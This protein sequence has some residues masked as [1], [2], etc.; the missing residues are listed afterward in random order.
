[1]S[2]APA[3]VNCLFGSL[4]SLTAGKMIGKNAGGL[5]SYC[6]INSNS[7]L[8]FDRLPRS[9]GRGLP[10]SEPPSS[11]SNRIGINPLFL[12]TLKNAKDTQNLAIVNLKDRRHDR[13]QTDNTPAAAEICRY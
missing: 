8:A 1:L 5:T 9:W 10:A 12:L 2:K 7:I 6:F 3:G 4:K 11:Y 13:Q